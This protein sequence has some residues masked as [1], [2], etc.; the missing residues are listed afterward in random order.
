MLRRAGEGRQLDF[1]DFSKAAQA[2][3]DDDPLLR[4]R[5]LES[6]S[7][8]DAMFADAYDPANG[9]PSYPPSRVYRICVLQFL[10]NL[11][12]A[13]AVKQ[14]G[15]NLLYRAFVGLGWNDEV[16]DSTV[17]CRFRARVG[18]E[19]IRR[20]FD[21]LLE[22]ARAL[23]L[24]GDAARVTDGTHIAA[25]IAKRSRR[26]LCAAGRRHVL[27]AIRR[28]DRELARDLAKRY[29]PVAPKALGS[30]EARLQEERSRT[31]AFLAEV[32]G[33]EALGEEVANRAALLRRV[34][35][36]GN[37]EKLESFDDQDARFG[38][39]T[40]DWTFS[41]YKAH[42]S[43]DPK[44]RLITALHVIPG[45]ESEPTHIGE[46][47]DREPGGLPTGAAV[48]GDAAYTNGPCHEEIRARG[49]EP[50][51]PRMKV[52]RQIEDF[53]YDVAN[54][55]LICPAGKA[56]IAK[57]RQGN[58]ALYQFSTRDCAACPLRGK[59]LRPSELH[60]TA[61]PRARVWL[62]DTLKPKMAAGE[63]G[64]EHRK[65]CYGERYK[66]EPVFSEQKGPRSRLGVA[67]YWGIIKVEIQ[68]LFT[69]IATNA[70][71]MV[72]ALAKR[73]SLEALQPL[74]AAA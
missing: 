28:L 71:R 4:L 64:S 70:L 10:H 40:R 41:G 57:T 53:H 59:C 34:A 43:I 51:S 22:K 52:E 8:L 36:E 17:L 21:G 5:A 63:A 26:E 24:L 3:P 50:V 29:P 38:H 67:R 9:R 45:D 30:P 48:I 69:A 2:V 35:L 1:A 62:G 25:K 47:L 55:R 72:R 37:P 56:S 7:E 32:E 39:K 54:D 13:A 18:P 73:S 12:D 11:S 20:A 74:T 16:P 23:G 33:K 15:F 68:A 46:L 65:R 61:K 27:N 66:I 60:G 44:S 42:E 49:G 31:A 19:R 58:G 14:V 6:D